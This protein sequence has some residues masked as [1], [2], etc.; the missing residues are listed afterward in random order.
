MLSTADLVFACR[1]LPIAAGIHHNTVTT[2]ETGKYAGKPETIA[3]M[4]KALEKAGVEFI[5][6]GVKLR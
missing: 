5:K 3:A 6:G 1:S 2:F 4:R